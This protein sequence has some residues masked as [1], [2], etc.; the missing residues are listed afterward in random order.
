M[1]QKL[2]EKT[3]EKHGHACPGVA[4]GFR[5][6]QEVKK[7][8]GEDEKVIGVT[9]VKNCAVD[10]VCSVTGLSVEEG[11]MRFDPSVEGF[12]FYALD[13]E[14]GWKFSIK[15]LEVAKEADPVLII[16]ASNRDMLYTI[17]PCDVPVAAV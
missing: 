2:W 5:I 15:T 8:F 17:E 14:E 12:L 4:I 6:G 7:I 3:V 1:D 9:S 11:T 16:L 13:D 10:G